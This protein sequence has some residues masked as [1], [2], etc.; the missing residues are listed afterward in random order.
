MKKIIIITLYISTVIAQIQHGGTP[1][2]LYDQLDRIN[3]IQVNTD[4]IVDRSFDP[5]VFQ[6]GTEYDVDIDVKNESQVYI[7]D[8]DTYTL[9]LGIHSDGAYGLGFNFSDFFLTPNAK[10]YFYDR[11]RTSFFGSLT[12]LNNKETDD[13]TTSIIKGSYVIIELTAPQ[14]E[15]NDIRLNIDTI[16]HDYT[17]IMNYYNT[18]DSDREDCNINVICPEGDDWRDQINGVLRV[19]MGGGLCSASLI[20]NTSNDRTPYVLFADHCVSGSTSGYVFYFNY[21]SSII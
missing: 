18:L 17:D 12:E 1:K 7:N 20:N 3:F 21:Q 14:N 15:I 19:S 9:V 16:I 13:L 2:F 4:L 6:F 11:E 5:M 8:D 10:L